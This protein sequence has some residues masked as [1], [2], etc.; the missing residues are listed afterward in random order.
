MQMGSLRPER[1]AQDP[2]ANCR[3]SPGHREPLGATHSPPAGRGEGG[4]EGKLDGE[5]GSATGMGED[6]W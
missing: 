4:E 3:R 6:V 1:V 2:A 5:A